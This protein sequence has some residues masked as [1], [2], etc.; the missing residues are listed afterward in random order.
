MVALLD[1]ILRTAAVDYELLPANPLAGI[2][3]RAHFP[4]DARHPREPRP[5]VL[6]PAD[7][8]RAVDVLHPKVVRLALAAA[9]TGLRWGELVAL[10][11]D[12]DVDFRSNRI[13]I[14]RAFYHRVPQTPKT[15]QSIRDIEM[16]PTVRRIMQAVPWHE[17]LVFSP[18]GTAAIGDGSWVKRQWQQ[19]QRLAGIKRP[20]RWHDLRHQFVSLLIAAGKHP[21]YIS[22]QAGHADPGFTLRRYGHLFETVRPTPVEWW[23]DLL[24]PSGCHHLATVPDGSGRHRVAEQGVEDPAES[25]G[26]GRV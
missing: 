20:I 8:T 21:L 18:D 6:E 11:I 17:G 2:L 15:E 1:A 14:T 4:T 9:L 22:R 25:V 7:F 3:R 13:R 23:D 19:A 12:E 5:Q 26:N 24:W 10:R 16:C